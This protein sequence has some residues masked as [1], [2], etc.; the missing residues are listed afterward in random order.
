MLAGLVEPLESPS[1]PSAPPDWLLPHQSDA[2]LR[3]R[4]ILARFGGVLI[5]DGVGLGKTYVALALAALEREGGG[6]AVAVVPA[7]MREEWRR[8]SS[9]VN[10]PLAVHS[11]A[12]LARGA[13]ALLPRCT[14][15]VVDEAHGF[16]N[17]RTR[18][19]DALARLT[20][21]R[22][23]ALLT[24][25]PFNNAPADL[26]A[27]L[28]L[29]APRD[30]FRELGVSD[31][32]RALRAGDPAATLALGAVSVCRTRRLVERRFP[33]L[34]A[35]FPRRRLAPPVRYDLDAAYGGRL[36]S[37]LAVLDELLA[38]QHQTGRGAA[39]LHLGLLRRLESSRAALR[40]S[41][42]RQRDFLAEV[43]RAGE[44]GVRLTRAAYRAA[45][46]RGEA[47]DAQLVMWSI[48][49]S[50][51]DPRPLAGVEACRGVVDRALAVVE[52]APAGIDPKI[53]ALDALLDGPLAG[54]KTLVFTEFRDT[55]FDLLRRLRKRRRVVAVVGDRAWAGVSALT[56]T[57]ALDAFAPAARGA[58]P[59][60]ALLGADVLIA[61][62][63]AGEGL[64][65]QDGEAVVNYD[66][67]WN[68]V[69]V[70]QRV[71]RIDRIGSR[72][73][74]IVV[75][76]LVPGGGFA[77][78]TGVLRRT[79]GKLVAAERA[80]AAEP[81]PLASLWWLD[82]VLTGERIERES[83]A[84]VAPFEARERW[85]ALTG[86]VE[87]RSRR[88]I[89]AAGIDHDGPPAAGVLL[90]MEWPDGRRLPLPFVAVGGEPT[91]RDAE[92]LGDLAERALAAAALPVEPGAFA[93]LLASALPDARSALVE[94][95]AARHGT[96][97]ASA[98]R[99][100]AL[101]LLL[102]A[103][104]ETAHRRGDTHDVDRALDRLARELPAGLDR[105][106][107]RI[108]SVPA[109][110]A[111]LARR[112]T[113]IVTSVPWQT[114]P[115]LDGAPR[116]VLVAAVVLAARCPSA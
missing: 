87:L 32:P 44:D 27:L 78:L 16:R 22:R 19:Y 7:A 92:A 31:L 88:P 84:R 113:E 71:G 97:D 26:A 50:G 54:R 55:A 66:L 68:P 74:E 115:R 5:A 59:P 18:R 36:R 23:V 111:D 106:I 41:L 34:R 72:H 77:D 15:I 102:R 94:L 3:A 82:D 112:V 17:P 56:R 35:A 29:F 58:A 20:A 65:L 28:H 53:E 75:A 30:R 69:R 76:H 99:R 49:S 62:D 93:T 80:P 37:L 105:L 10:V 47:D 45:V 57:E 98:G 114:G 33:D 48:L 96:E 108:L 8:A 13:P 101:A 109:V 103:A 14:L 104:S 86:S 40:R 9:A 79:R 63:V 43:G 11:H 85:R 21:G 4:A 67:P 64:N 1:V 24:A 2:V 38:V 42:L 90:S 91:R 95:S 52:G 83:W 110:N 61:T 73:A 81:D 89:L 12:D 100:A 46:P 70:M 51:A 116:L 39:L 25:T 6:D 107:A 60:A